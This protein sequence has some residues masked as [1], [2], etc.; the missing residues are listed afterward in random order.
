MKKKLKTRNIID[1]MEILDQRYLKN[2]P[3]LRKIVDE[4][5]EKLRIG[6]Q[7]YDLRQEAG[8]TQAELADLV[9]TTHSVISRLESADYDGHSLKMQTGAGLPLKV[10][11]VKES[12]Q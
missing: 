5:F 1:G 11:L 9:G 4:E 8:L 3:A 7:I 10:A 12:T 2:D 6:Q